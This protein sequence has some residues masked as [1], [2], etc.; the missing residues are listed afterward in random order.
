MAEENTLVNI[1][2]TVKEG[3]PNWD[4]L[5]ETDRGSFL[6]LRIL[7]EN[8]PLNFKN[9]SEC[10][11]ISKIYP[12]LDALYLSESLEKDIDRIKEEFSSLNGY[13]LNE[14]QNRIESLSRLKNSYTTKCQEILR[15]LS[16]GDLDPSKLKPIVEKV[17][18][19]K[20]KLK[21]GTNQPK[22]KGRVWTEEQ[23]ARAVEARRKTWEAKKK[24]AQMDK[25]E[26]TPSVVVKEEPKSDLPDRLDIARAIISKR[27]E[28][29]QDKI[30]SIESRIQSLRDEGVEL[31]CSMPDLGKE[32]LTD[33][34]K[35]LDEAVE[36]I[37]KYLEINK[38]SD[39]NG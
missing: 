29:V 14:T 25:V 6:C 24:V 36:I 34:M 8:C 11:G 13:Q 37:N 9:G 2:K 28:M 32:C 12:Y 31:E 38:T 4:K 19:P 1:Y 27:L 39:P 22:K 23:K 16:L 33:D 5:N 30:K 15:S 7:C 26:E 3:V 20:P 10:K 35:V 17:D 18:E 21:L